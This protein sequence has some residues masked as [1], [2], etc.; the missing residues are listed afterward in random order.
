MKVYITRHGES[1]SNAEGYIAFSYTG[2]SD[3]GMVDAK[4]LGERLAK[5]GIK[6]DAVYCSFLGEVKRNGQ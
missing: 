2:L 1:V 6:I 4:K 3:K 5:D